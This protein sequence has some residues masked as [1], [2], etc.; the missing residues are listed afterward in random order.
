[1]QYDLFSNAAPCAS[2]QI[3]RPHLTPPE[4]MSDDEIIAALPRANLSTAEALG[5]Q[6]IVRALGDRAVPALEQ[7]WQRFT[8]IAGPL[9][10]HRAV[11]VTL[12]ALETPLAGAALVRLLYT[13]TAET[14][15]PL[16]LTTAVQGRAAPPPERLA[17]W[18]EH[19]NPEVRAAAFALARFGR[20]TLDQLQTGLTDPYPIVQREALVTMGLL[21]YAVAKPGLLAELGRNPTGQVVHALSCIMDDDIVTHLGRCAHAHPDLRALIL[22]ELRDCDSPRVTGILK[23]LA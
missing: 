11:L 10:E 23:S 3:T 22:E 9:P 16:L 8:G 6:V 14:L 12:G 18:L 19:K 20:A 2:I 4:E 1:M 15:L 17:L 13:D 7:L 5:R 21:G